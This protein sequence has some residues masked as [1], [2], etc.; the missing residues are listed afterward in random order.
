MNTDDANPNRTCTKCKEVRPLS[1]FYKQKKGP[2]G[3][4]C[5]CKSCYKVINKNDYQKRGGKVWQQEYLKNKYGSWKWVRVPQ[6]NSTNIFSTRVDF[7]TVS[8]IFLA[9]VGIGLLLGRM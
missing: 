7:Y 1:E 9:G 8:W 4:H 6:K 5:W 3:L 2:G